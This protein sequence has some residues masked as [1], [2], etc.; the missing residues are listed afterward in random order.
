MSTKSTFVSA[1]MYMRR[2]R[3]PDAG[4][5]SCVTHNDGRA[6]ASLRSLPPLRFSQF[7]FHKSPARHDALDH[8]NHTASV[9]KA[10][11][12]TTSTVLL[13][14]VES[15]TATAYTL[16]CNM[17]QLWIAPAAMPI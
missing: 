10:N 4:H 8:C 12:F 17:V 5:V 16:V 2:F 9:G 15:E 7:F 6:N 1:G 11:S 3:N 13:L 14:R